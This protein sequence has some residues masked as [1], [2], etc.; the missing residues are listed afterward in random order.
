MKDW[1][2]FSSLHIVL[3]VRNSQLV[4][5]EYFEDKMRCPYPSYSITCHSCHALL[6]GVVGRL[7]MLRKGE[8]RSWRYTGS[9]LV[10]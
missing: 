6:Q 1:K 7:A 10:V 8:L 9:R 5:T 3:I 4:T 2:L